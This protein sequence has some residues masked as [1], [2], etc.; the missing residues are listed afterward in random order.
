MAECVIGCASNYTWNELKY[1][2]NS[3]NKTNFMGDVV[4]VGNNISQE[5]I[6][7]LS[8]KGVTVSPALSNARNLPPN[9][10]RFLM[11]WEYLKTC[12]KTYDRV[13][14]TD[15]KDVIF[16]ANPSFDMMRWF[17]ANPN[18]NLIVSSEGLLY[19]D[20]PWGNLNIQ[21]AFGNTIHA[22][23]A[24]QLIYNVGVIAGRHE[25]I[26]SLMLMIY[27]MSIN[28]PIP[29]VDQAVFNFLLSQEPYRKSTYFSTNEDA[30]AIQLG[31]TYEAVKSGAGDLGMIASR[32]PSSLIGYQLTYKDGQPIIDGD[33]V[34]NK[35]GQVFTVVHQWDRVPKLKD[36][37]MKKYG[38]N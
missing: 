37:I 16:Q 29:I 22:I 24:N 2:V 14:T 13:L 33:T 8:E 31:T 35:D 18:R 1:W 17:D 23:L 30:W 36:A 7:K 6:D 27:Q 3:L 38:D 9:V 15:T 11:I 25:A 4:I 34:R 5:T 32:D 19:K 21:Q 20:E 26:E 10:A 28:R 12:G